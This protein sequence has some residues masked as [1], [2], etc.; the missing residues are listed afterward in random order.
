MILLI[1][2]LVVY[3]FFMFLEIAPIIKSRNTFT[4]KKEF[5]KILR[6]KVILW[7]F[8]MSAIIFSFIINW[9]GIKNG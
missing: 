1:I 8:I 7:I 4:D 5:Y 9:K 3:G 2:F 6:K